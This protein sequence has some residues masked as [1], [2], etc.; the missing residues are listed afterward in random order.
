MQSSK[1]APLWFY[2]TLL[3]LIV[4]NLYTVIGTVL[5]EAQY[6]IL[7]IQFSP[8]LR[9]VVSGLW[10]IV[11]CAL[12]RGLALRQPLAFM[13]IVPVMSLYGMANLAGSIVFARSDYS[14]GQVGFQVIG[15]VIVLLPL[16]WIALRGGWMKQQA[17]KFDKTTD[18][19]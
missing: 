9:I 16:W 13:W 14:R 4:F 6:R 17:I 5:Q 15:T 19:E 11:F 7:D 8:V 12:L 10:V 18:A 2:P 1:S 3:F